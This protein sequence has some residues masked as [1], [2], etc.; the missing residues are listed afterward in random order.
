MSLDSEEKQAVDAWRERRASLLRT[1]IM[2]EMNAKLE[3]FEADFQQ[4]TP[5]LRVLVQT[6]T[7]SERS[8]EVPCGEQAMITVWNPSEEQLETLQED[9]Q[10]RITNI[11]VRE[12]RYD[13]LVQ[14]SANRR[15]SFHLMRR[16]G[17]DNTKASPET[18]FLSVFQVHSLSKEKPYRNRAD[19]LGVV[20]TVTSLSG[21]PGGLLVHLTDNSGLLLRVECKS[22]RPILKVLVMQHSAR[23][24]VAE[25]LQLATFRSLNVMDFDNSVG[26]AVAQF[27]DSSQISPTCRSRCGSRELAIRRWI[28]SERGRRRLYKLACALD[29]G[30]PFARLSTDS[31]TVGY[32]SD[33]HV[34]SKGVF[35]DVDSVGYKIQVFKLPVALLRDL[36][37]ACGD[38]Q[39]QVVF[40][41]TQEKKASSLNSIQTVFRA[42]DKPFRFKLRHLEEPDPDCP[43]CQYEIHEV[44]CV[45]NTALADLYSSC[46]AN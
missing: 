2:D 29:V 44:K 15:T 42:R 16:D 24:S 32:I 36:V 40:G 8:E 34:T 41:L 22:E 9:R 26:C 21:S 35:L 13:G 10:V 19:F 46:R 43:S 28:N 11:G 3:E 25:A 30:V 39:S 7:F 5:F 45:D 23:K 1:R 18:N 4:S 37:E 12:N 20:L 38:G 17:S 33:F 6:A 27:D 14:L 31:I